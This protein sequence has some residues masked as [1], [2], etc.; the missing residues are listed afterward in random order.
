MDA[1]GSEDR[2][3]ELSGDEL[4]GRSR[5][6]GVPVA[7][8]ASPPRVPPVTRTRQN[9]VFVSQFRDTAPGTDNE[10]PRGHEE[11]TFRLMVEMSS[12]KANTPTTPNRRLFSFFLSGNRLAESKSPGFQWRGV[13][14]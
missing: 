13:C 6:Q 4:R 5:R 11:S 2:A 12:Q 9:V 10:G 8:P 7:G 1:H 3:L 14:M